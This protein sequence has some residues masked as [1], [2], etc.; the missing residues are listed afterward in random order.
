M[1]AQD[2]PLKEIIGI[3]EGQL[4]SHERAQA[5]ELLSKDARARDGLCSIEALLRILQSHAAIGDN[6]LAALLVE[7]AEDPDALEPRDRQTVERVLEASP[8]RREQIDAL[9]KPVDETQLAP[10]SAG[11]RNRMLARV[12]AVFGG[13]GEKAPD[14]DAR[15]VLQAAIRYVVKWVDHEV[16]V[17][18]AMGS[19]EPALVP[20]RGVR[21]RDIVRIKEQLPAH[22]LNVMI[23]RLPDGLWL[24]LVHADNVKTQRPAKGRFSF[25]TAEGD[26][27]AAGVLENGDA[28]IEDVE[29]GAYHLELEVDGE[30][31]VIA[32]DVEPAGA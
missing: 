21:T 10:V 30:H 13:A 27:Y 18:S 24:V 16:R 9:R 19:A 17:L 22:A 7:Y 31:V 29:P 12:R 25:C 32:V 20:V 4:S 6:R 1:K 11:L 2:V 8:R 3:L 15:D 14:T 26:V 23:Q 5:L 28:Q